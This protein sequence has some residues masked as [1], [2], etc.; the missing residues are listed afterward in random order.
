MG[1]IELYQT[2]IVRKGAERV[3]LTQEADCAVRILYCLAKN[4]RRMEGRAVGGEMAVPLRFCLKILG[5]LA[6]AGLVTSYK[7][8]GG[9]YE[10]ARGAD[11]IT[12]LDAIAAVEGPYRLSRFLCEPDGE[13]GECTRGA[14]GSC[15][16]QRVFG[17]VSATVNRELAAVTLDS[18]LREEAENS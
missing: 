5:K 2:G 11:Q 17:R 14:S 3:H 8:N 10:L 4:G 13:A 12:L 6:A 15:P 1:Y 16:F 7:G 18:I 9:G